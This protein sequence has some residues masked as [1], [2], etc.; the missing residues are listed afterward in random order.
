M[1]RYTSG[2]YVAKFGYESPP[3]ED[4]VHLTVAILK[5]LNA[6]LRER[7]P[8]IRFAILYWDN[9]HSSMA[10]DLGTQLPSIGVPVMLASEVFP[11]SQPNPIYLPNGHPTAWAHD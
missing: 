7:Y 8:G 5:T 3:D 4:D 10:T 11:S 6:R 1:L 9:E 2:L